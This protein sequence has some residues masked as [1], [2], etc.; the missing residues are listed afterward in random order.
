MR[1]GLPR[2]ESL[3]RVMDA[4][5]GLSLLHALHLPVSA[6]S[7][8]DGG[9][10]RATLALSQLQQLTIDMLVGGRDDMPQSAILTNSV[11]LFPRARSIDVEVSAREDESW[12][13]PMA[14][15]AAALTQLHALRLRGE[16]GPDSGR[17]LGVALENISAL[18][19]LR[20]HAIDGNFNLSNT[21][22]LQLDFYKALMQFSGLT[23][24]HT[25][26]LPG[27][28]SSHDLL[29]PASV[30]YVSCLHALQKLH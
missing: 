15:D 16:S 20:D 18:S 12:L 29:F 27:M 1:N 26:Y 17:R 3:R 11:P 23:A 13:E 30:P 4:A 5:A 9:L 19:S 28:E 25:P 24:L 2:P 6:Y 22:D 10:V 21:P 8:D 7:V 14:T